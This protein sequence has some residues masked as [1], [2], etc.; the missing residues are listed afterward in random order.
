MTITMILVM[1]VQELETKI[2]ISADYSDNSDPSLEQV[3]K[4]A[5][6]RGEPVFLYRCGGRAM[7][8]PAE[9]YWRMMDE[10]PSMRIYQALFCHFPGGQ[11][12]KALSVNQYKLSYYKNLVTV[13]VI[14]KKS[15][16]ACSGRSHR[17]GYKSS[18]IQKWQ[19]FSES[20]RKGID[21]FELQA[22][23][24]CRVMH[25]ERMYRIAGGNG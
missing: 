19:K 9:Y 15:C 5:M 23:E 17:F 1:V 22:V 8:P 12:L 10:H 3:V 16:D 7:Q 18:R 25:D 13:F 2:K 14:R 21:R 6:R 20:D 4:K 24:L 11:S